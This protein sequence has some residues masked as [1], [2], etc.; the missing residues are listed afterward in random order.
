MRPEETKPEVPDE[1]PEGLSPEELE[2]QGVQ[3]LP[4]RKALSLV[5]PLV[6]VPLGS[7]VTTGLLPD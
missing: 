6:T 5:H 2:E 4:Q 1:E 7:A 3:D